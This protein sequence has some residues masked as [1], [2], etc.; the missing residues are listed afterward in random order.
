M[1]VLLVVAHPEA[2]SFN[3][4]LR[5]AVVSEVKRLGHHI[6]V[7]DLYQQ[8]FD[9]RGGPADFAKRHN[10]AQFHYQ[11]EQTQA[12]LNGTF[13]KDLA[14]EQQKLKDADLLILQ[15]PI[16]WGGEPAMLK[17][18]FD[19]VAAYGVAYA[20]GKRF[21][22][23][24]FKG[25]RSL[26]SV[27]TGGTPRRFTDEG[28]YGDINKVLWPVQQLFLGYLGFTLTEPQV[29]YAVARTDEN[30]RQQYIDNLKARVRQLL[31]EPVDATPIPSSQEL[32]A[33]LGDRDWRH[34][35]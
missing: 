18:W 21:E 8:G 6:T 25:R 5:D 14:D 7:S 34:P 29:A 15:F 35:G 19:K 28:G 13:A 3:G 16:W 17:G 24:L 12:A 30:T 32:L 33:E 11:T 31:A 9:P 23:G 26:V 20:D 10:N 1:K 27:T 2:N 4:A 22:S